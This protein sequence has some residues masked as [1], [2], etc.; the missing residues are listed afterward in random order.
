MNIALQ[1]SKFLA[2][3]AAT[4]LLPLLFLLTG[5]ISDL[6]TDKPDKSLVSLNLDTATMSVPFVA[7]KGQLSSDVAFYASTANTSMFVTQKGELVYSLNSKNK[8]SLV[9]QKA[10]QPGWTLIETFVGADTTPSGKQSSVTNISSFV[11]NDPD[12]WFQQLPTY[13][14][15]ALGEA[16]SGVY[17]DLIAR[18]NSVEKLF[19]IMPGADPD[20][21][22][23]KVSGAK[24]VAMSANGALDITT[25]LGQVQL[26]KPLAWQEKNNTQ[27]PV[28]VAYVL[29]EQGY[30]FTLGEYDAS[31]P[32]MIDP[33]LQSTYIGGSD[34]DIPYSI[35]IHPTSGDVYV[36]GETL[37]ADF[38]GVTGG[39]QSSLS[40]TSDLFIA[41]FNAELTTLEQATYLGGTLEEDVAAYFRQ[42]LAISS[43]GDA[44]YLTAGTQSVDFPGT[45]GGA[46]ATK[47]GGYADGV[48]VKLNTDL[49]AIIQS[50]YAGGTGTDVT[51]AITI[52][53][54]SGDV[55]VAGGGWTSG[56]P[57]TAGGAQPVSD[58]TGL[59]ITS[60][61]M[62]FNGD[63]TSVLQS[64]YLGGA[65][66]DNIWAIR[67]HP[68]NGDLYVV[69]M[70]RS[71]DFPAISGGAQTT[72]TGNFDDGFVTRLSS[73]LTAFQQS[74]FIGGSYTEQVM[75]L[76]FHPT[77]GN[78]YVGGYTE[79]DDFPATTGG[80]QENLPSNGTGFISMLNTDLTSIT[81]SSYL[82]G[83]SA[84]QVM[85][86]SFNTT[87][88][89][90]YAT[91]W[92]YSDDFPAIAGGAQSVRQQTDGFVSLIQDDLQ[93]I[94]QSTYVGGNSSE[95]P[96]DFAIN[97]T[98][99]DI[100]ITGYTTSDSLPAI[101]GG[102]I[103]ANPGGALSGFI[104]RIDSTLT[105]AASPADISVTPLSND[106]G[107]LLI[108]NSSAP[109]EITITN[110]GSIALNVSNIAL[111]DVTDFS[112][113][114]AGGSSP[115]NATS[116]A[117]A[118]SSSC[119]VS[120]TFSPT[121]TGALS[122]TL[123]VSSDD[124]DEANVV[125]NL[126]GS[127]TNV[128]EADINVTPAIYSYGFVTIGNT[129]PEVLFTITNNGT[130]DL[131]VSDISITGANAAEFNLNLNGGSPACAVSN[132]TITPTNN[133][134]ITVSFT[135]QSDGARNASIVIL[136]NDPDSDTL[137]ITITGT[138]TGPDD[139]SGGGGCFIATAAY[140]THMA[141][142]VRYL[143]AFRDQYLLQNKLGRKLVHWYYDISPPIA[144]R[145]RENE[146][147]RSV[148]RIALKP[149]VW[150]SQ[151]VV[152]DT[153]Y[154]QQTE[155]Q[156]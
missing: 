102:A 21:I 51:S 95:I 101:T 69:G 26:S 116:F 79:S 120:V 45:T 68:A 6:A 140:G 60:Y 94:H 14:S 90:L 123:T 42:G 97:N 87:T 152:D 132:P 29:D 131:L 75:D 50:S 8:S 133:C 115:C 114:L 38:P 121:A 48:V 3:C 28:Q 61:I 138:G 92:A 139:D 118:G 82:G 104:S 4:F 16:W 56:V 156:P 9:Q 134:K 40:G 1:K 88:N 59:R 71:T 144:D 113:D 76:T 103:T 52:H 15:I 105:G 55:Y 80:F 25:G 84:D 111:A 53:P 24:Q 54:T 36:A 12:K 31:L 37:S 106:F 98:T 128:A 141:G 63:L 83:S 2:V 64:T 130:V 19:T 146:F 72:I 5:V 147:M 22:K 57:G 35:A 96:N 44:V 117:L 23:I 122:T 7:N 110:T 47:Q 27:V 142:D 155:G 108:G 154:Q 67:V 137:T 100:Y 126:D 39:I 129:T 148:V 78:V 127:G 77:N 65:E 62:R 49:T 149:L 151:I 11:G 34:A 86:L 10:S 13:K 143:R 150:M 99:G 70:T 58:A 30:G 136:S 66:N 124:A 20:A 153:V 18:A 145:L 91:G 81:Q 85:S 43:A 107:Q 93:V 125:V 112:L 33:I 32:V 41:R 119:T 73:D 109:L 46:L 74:T 135:P 17:V 89:Q